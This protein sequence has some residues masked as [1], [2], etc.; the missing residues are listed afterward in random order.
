MYLCMI[1][2]CQYKIW[3]LI[4]ACVWISLKLQENT[5][6]MWVKGHPWIEDIGANVMNNK[7]CTQPIHRNKM[8]CPLLTKRHRLLLYDAFVGYFLTDW[9]GCFIHNQE[10]NDRL[11]LVNVIWNKVKLWLKYASYFSHSENI[12]VFMFSWT[13]CEVCEAIALSA[14]TKLRLSHP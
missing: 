10:K 13:I 3:K 9:I 14:E 4:C 2:F 6:R 12:Y 1:R 8:V 11:V 7:L 5:K